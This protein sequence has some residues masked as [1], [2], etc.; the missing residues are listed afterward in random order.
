MR[1]RSDFIPFE[2]ESSFSV[3]EVYGT[4]ETIYSM[5]SLQ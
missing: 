1:Y 4:K 5:R 2:N 3:T